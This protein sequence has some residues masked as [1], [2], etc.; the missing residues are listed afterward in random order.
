MSRVP[1]SMRA[2]LGGL[3]LALALAVGA[4]GG[5]DPDQ[6]SSPAAS[7]SADPQA[8]YP[9]TDLG[10]SDLI[11]HMAATGDLALLQSLRPTTADYQ[12]LF[13][14]DFAERAQRAYEKQMWSSMPTTPKPWADPDQTEVRVWG[15]KTEDIRKW[16]TAVRQNFP[17]GYNKIKHY[18]KPGLTMYSIKVVRPGDDLGMAFNGLTHVNG[19]WAYFPKPWRVLDS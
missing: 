14:P 8:A 11:G 2:G 12:A 7:A 1:R 16:T 3:V 13:E 5:S 15:A 4:C 6:P 9:A 18:L 19:H 10:A 17:G